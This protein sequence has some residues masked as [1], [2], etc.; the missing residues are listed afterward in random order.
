MK[1]IVTA[2][3]PAIEAEIDPRFGRG[4]YFLIIDPDTLAWQA[5]PN[6]GKTAPG[7][8]G[9]RAAQFVSEQDCAAVISGDFGPNAFE[10]LT[11]AGVAMYTFGTCQTVNEVLTGYKDGQLEPFNNPTHSERA[12]HKG[13][14]D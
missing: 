1:I 3:S 10:A 5:E 12:R 8:A 9:I 7:G 14:A 11:A 6:P 2:S 13:A 4:S